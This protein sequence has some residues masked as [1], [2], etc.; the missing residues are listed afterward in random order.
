VL[1]HADAAHV[2]HGEVEQH[3]AGALQVASIQERSGRIE[4]FDREPEAAQNAVE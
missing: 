3:A 2:R 4:A 1:L